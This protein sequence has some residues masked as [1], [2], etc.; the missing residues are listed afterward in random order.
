MSLMPKRSFG[1]IVNPSLPYLGILLVSFFETSAFKGQMVLTSDTLYM[2]YLSKDLLQGGSIFDW[3]LTQAPDYFPHMFVYLIIS[4]FT[5][6]AVT[7]L[8]LITLFQVSLL[9]ILFFSIFR[10]LGHSKFLSFLESIG[11][12]TLINLFQLHSQDWIYFYKTNNHFSS[13]VLGLLVLLILLEAYKSDR[14]GSLKVQILLFFSVFLGT[15]STITFVYAISMPLFFLFTPKVLSRVDFFSRKVFFLVAVIVGT[16][17]ALFITSKTSSGSSLRSR[18]VFSDSELTLVQDFFMRAFTRNMINSGVIVRMIFIMALATMIILALA[19]FCFSIGS[20]PNFEHGRSFKMLLGFS[21]ASLFSSAT[22]TILSGGIV[23]E[24]FLRY[25]W[26]SIFFC[27]LSALFAVTELLRKY[28][29]AHMRRYPIEIVVIG[30]ILILYSISGKPIY[31]TGTPFQ[32]AAECVVDLQTKGIKLESGVADYWYARS[33]DYLSSART[34][35]YAALNTLEPF[36]W[37]TTLETLRQETR[38]NYILLHTNPEPFNFNYENVK[39][40]LPS[41]SQKFECAR[42][43]VVVYFYENDSLDS[44]VKESR[45]SFLSSLK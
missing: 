45:L 37:M 35:T 15:L 31:N 11:L 4:L 32:A 19:Y 16:V 28:R 12:L 21:L 2:H 40:W 30:S 9:G 43:D 33:V 34:N 22:L 27:G 5:Q 41:P 10:I 38:Y 13:V 42:S 8:F 44:L 20:F 17:L 23:D 3:N 6:Q 7:Q 1:S 29:N 25:F 26:P 39:D 36:F 24:F 18:L 14:F